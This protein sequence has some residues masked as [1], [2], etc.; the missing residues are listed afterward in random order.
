MPT[1]P[2]LS[3][4]YHV[5]ACKRYYGLIRQSDE[6]R[7]AWLSQLTLAGLCP[8]R[9]V[10]LTFPSLSCPAL[11]VHA[12]TPTPPTVRFPLMVHPPAMGAFVY[13]VATRLFRTCLSLVSARGHFRGGS[14][15]VRLR[16]ARWLGR[17]TRPRRAL[18]QRPTGP[19]LR[20]SLP[21]P[22]SPP[23]GVCYH[24]S[25]QPPIAEA[26]FSPARLSRIEGCT[27]NHG[28]THLFI[29]VSARKRGICRR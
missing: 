14:F 16:P 29:L 3:T 18:L 13:S 26:G 5:R 23:T 10:R 7:P 17:L 20:Q 6:L 28:R 9:A 22:G 1:G 11:G 27:Q 21:Q 8:C 4:V 12:A 19:R 15:L 24:Y 2:W 25:A